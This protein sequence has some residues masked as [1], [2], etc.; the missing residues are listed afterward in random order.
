MGWDLQL[1][2]ETSQNLSRSELGVNLFQAM[3]GSDFFVFEKIDVISYELMKANQGRASKGI[4]STLENKVTNLVK[5][6]KEMLGEYAE[7]QTLFDI[8]FLAK[9]IDEN[10]YDRDIGVHLYVFDE[11]FFAYPGGLPTGL[12]YDADSYKHYSSYVRSYEENILRLLDELEVLIDSGVTT[13]RGFGL[14][15]ETDVCSHHFCF[16]KDARNFV[17]DLDY[18]K[19]KFTLS[20]LQQV[21]SISEGIK[22]EEILGGAIIWCEEGTL[23]TLRQFYDNLEETLKGSQDNA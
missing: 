18:T 9:R 15:E 11:Q 21:V 22:S 14:E 1:T 23:R 4:V 5:N 17:S 10:D 20:D 7:P 12:T 16:H 3:L 13:I 6:F 19:E 2:L 8:T